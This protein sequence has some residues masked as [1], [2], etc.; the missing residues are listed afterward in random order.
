MQH[1]DVAGWQPLML[2]ALLGALGKRQH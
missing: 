2:V 1:Y